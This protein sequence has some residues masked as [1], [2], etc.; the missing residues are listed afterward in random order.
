MTVNLTAADKEK[1]QPFRSRGE[2]VVT[3]VTPN[4]DSTFGIVGVDQGVGTSFGSFVSNYAVTGYPAWNLAGELEF[5]YEGPFETTTA[6]GDLIFCQLRVSGPFDGANLP[7]AVTGSVT[8]VGGTGRFLGV[9]G[10]FETSAIATPVGF[11]YQS[12]GFLVQAVKPSRPAK[13]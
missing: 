10:D 1:I 13:H 9:T 6:S 4:S 3:S 8:V 11:N 5:V 12:Q 7:G 2:I